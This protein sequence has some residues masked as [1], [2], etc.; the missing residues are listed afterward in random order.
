MP[1]LSLITLAIMLVM[2]AGWLYAQD[3]ELSVSDIL[4]RRVDNLL[5]HGSGSTL[6][7]TYLPPE[8]EYNPLL[9]SLIIDGN[10]FI[11]VKNANSHRIEAQWP[12]MK[13]I[14]EGLNEKGWL[15]QAQCTR[16][17]LGSL[18]IDHDV[19][20][21]AYVIQL[22][23]S[24][25]CYQQNLP[26]N[27]QVYQ[28]ILELQ[29]VCPSTISKAMADYLLIPLA[30]RYPQWEIDAP[31]AWLSPK[32]N[33]APRD[34]IEYSPIH[35][36]PQ[37]FWQTV[38]GLEGKLEIVKAKILNAGAMD[39]YISYSFTAKPKVDGYYTFIFVLTQEQFT[40]QIRFVHLR[41]HRNNNISAQPVSLSPDS[42]KAFNPLFLVKTD[43]PFNMAWHFYPGGE[44]I[45]GGWQLADIVYSADRVPDVKTCLNRLVSGNR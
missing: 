22:F 23:N 12:E 28:Q 35:W 25:W 4:A 13:Q 6:C 33:P 26:C 45:P 16:F 15:Q 31:R 7:V 17:P 24:G 38:Y 9:P 29:I 32:P 18:P 14:V 2:Q 37:R 30:K 41:A 1:R 20:R 10:K 36:N 44:G 34:P 39:G 8:N 21:P 11:P 43:T 5:K 42:D 19:Q 27:A 40:Q 3:V